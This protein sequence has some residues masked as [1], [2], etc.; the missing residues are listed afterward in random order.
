MTEKLPK[1][2][3]RIPIEIEIEIDRLAMILQKVSQDDGRGY[4]VVIKPENSENPDQYLVD[5]VIKRNED[6]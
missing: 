6:K 4:F 2:E 1:P 3:V 5:V